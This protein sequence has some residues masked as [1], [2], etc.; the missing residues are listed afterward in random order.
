MT[1]IDKGVVFS[2]AWLIKNG[3][4]NLAKSILSEWGIT[5]S[6]LDYAYDTADED[7]SFSADYVT[8]LE[9]L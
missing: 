9:I 4:K 3:E 1:D 2:A 5:K 7:D 6:D 8:I